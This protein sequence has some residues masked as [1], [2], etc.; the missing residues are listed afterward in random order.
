[1]AKEINTKESKINILAAK[2][3][4]KE[5]TPSQTVLPLGIEKNADFGGAIG[6]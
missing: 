4:A 6:M 2:P 1:M 3:G 5:I